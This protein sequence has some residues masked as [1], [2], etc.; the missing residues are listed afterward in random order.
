MLPQ[1]QVNESITLG[2]LATVLRARHTE[3]LQMKVRCDDVH[4]VVVAFNRQDLDPRRPS[5]ALHH[6]NS[7]RVHRLIP[8][9]CLRRAQRFSCGRPSSHRVESNPARRS[10]PA[11]MKDL[12]DP[13]QSSRFAPHTVIV[14]KTSNSMKRCAGYP[15]TGGVLGAS[16]LSGAALATS[17][18]FASAASKASAKKSTASG[19][20]DDKQQRGAIA[21]T[22]AVQARLV[23]DEDQPGVPTTPLIK[24]LSSPSGRWQPNCRPPCWLRDVTNRW[25]RNRS[26]SSRSKMTC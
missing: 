15:A 12:F 11:S 20:S 7:L 16:V 14:T 25:P 23:V 2:D 19:L 26:A 4:D 3:P 13:H 18:G 9:S 10:Q 22:F 21:R 8:R 17:G 5:V 24:G 6:E 1:R